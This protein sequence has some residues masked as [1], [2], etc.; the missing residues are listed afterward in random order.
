[1]RKSD[2]FAFRLAALTTK[3]VTAQNQSYRK[4][5]W[6][7]PIKLPIWLPPKLAASAITHFLKGELATAAMCR[8]MRDRLGISMGGHFLELQA[9]DEQRHAR[10]YSL[11]LDKLGGPDPRPS[12]LADTY[13][14]A[15]AWQ[16]PPQAIILAYHGV[17]ERESMRLQQVIDK[18]LPCP[19]FR[20]LSAAIAQDEARHI[21]FGRLYLGETLPSL[22]KTERLNIYR[23]I[24]ALWFDAVRATIS[25]YAP[26]G[27]TQVYGGL[28]GWMANEWQE[29]MDDMET[30]SLIGP[31][32]RHEFA[33]TC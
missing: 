4:F 10:L 29:R 2:S 25:H 16:G 8:Q 31:G 23:W 1:M 28:S 11:Y 9:L 20:D 3:I 19:L 32:E 6:E 7:S 12:L 15:T 33:G 26:P 27:M 18:W 17:L 14:R 21:A 22:P 13:E 5:D 24:Q 30:L